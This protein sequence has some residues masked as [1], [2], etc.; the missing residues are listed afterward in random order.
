MRSPI[1]REL[2]TLRTYVVWDQYSDLSC[3]GEVQKSSGEKEFDL[4]LSGTITKPGGYINNFN[5]VG[6]LRIPPH[7]V[8]SPVFDNVSPRSHPARIAK[9]STSLV[10]HVF[11]QLGGFGATQLR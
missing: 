10:P 7:T 4:M 5:R 3:L 6:L 11:G 2:L 9:F 8:T 1:S